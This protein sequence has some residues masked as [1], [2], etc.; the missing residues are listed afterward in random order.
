MPS[1]LHWFK[2]EAAITWISGMMLLAVVYYLTQGLFLVDAAVS[3]ITPGQATA[4]GLGT[5]FIAWFVYDFLWSSALARSVALATGL[6]FVLAAG[7]T[8]LFCRFLSGRAAYIHVGALFGTLMV[9]NVWLRI[10]PAQQKMIDA[11]RGGRTPDFTL[12]D[13]AKLRSVHNSYM[14]FP[15]L[16]IMLSNHFPG[17]YGNRLNWLILGLLILLGGAV[18]HVMIGKGRSRG[19][20]MLPA[21]GSLA[22]VAVLTAPAST[23][24]SAIPDARSAAGPAPTFAQVQ[25]VVTSRCVACHSLNPR[26]KTFGAAPAG[27]TFDDPANIVR[28]A[29]RIYVRAVQTRTMPLGNKTG[30]TD[31][32]RALLGRW[33]Q[34]GARP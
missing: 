17:T 28:M 3:K 19:W 15:V 26:D 30:I 23:F 12:S 10:L 32:E 9:A 20:A 18:R 1:T 33:I 2:W 34:A 13:R 4:L 6:S 7:A 24:G 8:F 16:F 25:A 29:P 5:I 11:T 14:T 22:A 27:V 21:V 31:E